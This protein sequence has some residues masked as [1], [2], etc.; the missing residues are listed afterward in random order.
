MDIVQHTKED[1]PYIALI[2]KLAREFS[3]KT[4]ARISLEDY[5]NVGLA[6]LHKARQVY[7][8]ER[9]EKFITLAHTIIHNEMNDEWAQ[10]ANELSCSQYHIRETPG[11]KEEV[12]FQNATILS[13]SRTV[14][15]EDRQRLSD[16]IPASSGMSKNFAGSLPSGMREPAESIEQAEVICKVNQILNTLPE[17]DQDVVKRKIFEGQTFEEIADARHETWRQVNYRYHK[18]LGNL[19]NRFI[20]AGLD[21][22][23]E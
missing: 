4:N 13:L 5:V 14:C 8:K 9:P 18:V 20:E 19:K 16:V 7:E 1:E 21:T 15:E 12:D 6:A 17:D 23:V 2:Y 11:A 22:Y 3:G 10:A